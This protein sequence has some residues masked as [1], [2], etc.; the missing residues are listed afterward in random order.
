[1]GVPADSQAMLIG[2]YC[3]SACFGGFER[4]QKRKKKIMAW[5]GVLAKKKRFRWV[6]GPGEIKNKDG[7]G[8]VYG[9]EAEVPG[10][11]GT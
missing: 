5:A 1:M 3:Y 11:G 2:R 6:L 10:A 8:S 9:L 7:R 4:A